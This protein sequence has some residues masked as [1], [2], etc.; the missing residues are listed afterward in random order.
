MAKPDTVPGAEPDTVPGVDHEDY[1]G[2]WLGG[3]LEA[4]QTEFGL[5]WVERG[6]VRGVGRRGE[7]H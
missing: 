1:P 2:T 5:G 3:G 4:G 7:G 6:L